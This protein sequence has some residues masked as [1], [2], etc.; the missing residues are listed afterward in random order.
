MPDF[1]RVVKGPIAMNEAVDGEAQ[2][3]GIVTQGISTSRTA[4]TKIDQ[5]AVVSGRA[6]TGLS[7]DKGKARHREATAETRP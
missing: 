2:V 6:Q 1:D 7:R 4:T 5:K 3:F